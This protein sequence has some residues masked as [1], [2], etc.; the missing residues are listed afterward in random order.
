MPD[1]EKDGSKIQ[2][3]E[4]GVWWEWRGDVETGP[5][6]EEVRLC[7]DPSGVWMEPTGR[8]AGE[9]I[10]I[11]NRGEIEGTTA[12]NDEHP[13]SAARIPI[14]DESHLAPS[15]LAA[16]FDVPADALR[17]RL[18]RWRAQNAAGWIE[19]PDRSS[20]DSKYLY[21]VGAVRHLI[22]PTQSTSERPAK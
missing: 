21:R 16:L 3:F 9:P 5:P 6:V 4:D 1:S 8:P 12:H 18:N 11:A 19:N 20:R 15:R 10:P 17:S 13:R 14:D 7:R 2:V 22:V